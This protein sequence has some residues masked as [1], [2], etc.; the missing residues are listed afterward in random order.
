MVTVRY[1]KTGSNGQSR[2]K[3]FFDREEAI[4]HVQNLIEEKTGKGYVEL[5]QGSVIPVV[6][7]ED[8]GAKKSLAPQAEIAEVKSKKV[9]PAKSSNPAKDMQATPQSLLPL[10]DKDVA[11]NRL[12]AKHPRS[13]AELLEVLSHNSDKATRQSVAGNP[14]TLLQTYV[15]LGQQFPKQ[16]LANPALDLLLLTNPALMEEVPEALLIRLLKESEC[17]GT[18]LT[19]AAS[20][21]QAKVQLAVAMNAN[22]PEKALEKLRASK[23]LVVIDSVQTSFGSGLEQDPE[24]A[25]EQELKKRIASLTSAEFE[26][27]WSVEDLG[28]AQWSALPLALRLEKAT[29]TRGLD[30]SSIARVLRDT[31]RT[32][33]S[34]KEILP[35]FSWWS[36]ASD[37]QTP[38]A[39]LDQFANHPDVEF[40]QGVARNPSVSLVTLEFLARD[41]H[42]WVRSNIALHPLTPANVLKV[43]AR[44]VNEE[45]LSSVASNPHTPAETLANLAKN[46]YQSVR[47]NVAT[48]ISTPDLIRIDLQEKLAGNKE[49]RVRSKVASSPTTSASALAI[50]AKDR[51][52]L[53]RES[54]A[55]NPAISTDVA[56]LLCGD[57]D[58]GVRGA[59]AQNLATPTH[60]LRILSRDKES[61][62]REKVALNINTPGSILAELSVDSRF[63]V[64]ENVAGNSHAPPSLLDA[65][66]TNVDSS[67]RKCVASNPS[68]RHEVLQELADDKVGVVRSEALRNINTPLAALNA[69][70]FDKNVSVRQALASQADR[71]LEI[72][73]ALWQDSNEDVRQALINC[74]DLSPEILSEMARSTDLES[75]LVVLLRH[76]NLRAKDVELVIEKLLDI[77]ASKSA[78]YQKELSNANVAVRTAA[79]RNAVTSYHGKDPNKAA[80][81]KRPLAPVMA[82]C[83]GPFIEI[84]RLVKLVNSTDWLV[85]AS[86]ARH[87]GTPPNLLKKLT[88]DA[89]PLVGALAKKL[90]SSAA[91][92]KNEM[93]DMPSPGLDFG[94]AVA[95]VLNRLR[96][97]SPEKSP[98][99][100]DAVA[101]SVWG[102]YVEVA[103][104]LRVLS[105]KLKLHEVI[106]QLDT[107]L[108]ND[109][110][111]LMWELGCELQDSDVKATLASSPSCPPLVIKLLSA[112]PDPLVTL[113]VLSNSVTSLEIR[114]TL[115]KRLLTMR[116][117]QLESVAGDSRTPLAVLEVLAKSKQ[118][119]IRERVAGNVSTPVASLVMLAK[120]P[121]DSVRR[122]IAGNV[123]TPAQTLKSL[124]RQQKISVAGNRSTSAAVL[125]ALSIDSEYAVRA[126]V[127]KNSATPDAVLDRMSKDSEVSVRRGVAQNP[128]SSA[129]LLQALF[130][131]SS[132]DVRW[133]VILNR[134]A[135]STVWND[136]TEELVACG[137]IASSKA[138]EDLQA[139]VALLD[140]LSR[141][142]DVLLRAKV[143]QNVSV[144]GQTLANLT[145]DPNAWVRRLAKL[146]PAGP[147]FVDNCV[148]KLQKAL[149]RAANSRLG[150]TNFQQQPITRERF[151][152][153][154]DWLE[155]LPMDAD[156]QLLSKAARSKDWLVRF[157]AALHPGATKG[158]L[159]LL[160]ED[161]DADVAAVA[162]LHERDE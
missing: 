113:S 35:S 30:T 56:E 132:P 121:S 27:A 150:T 162:R 51:T 136:L 73:R 123:A 34:L 128:S 50:L 83:A 39:L 6:P 49:E 47:L 25:F 44:D 2:A 61:W 86:V 138:A 133:G 141:H 72:S 116:G 29:N 17:P 109:S 90:L 156:D 161:V 80:L 97:D 144:S 92:S 33:E 76:M 93:P 78:W 94:R 124:C 4:K 14:N 9:K 102:L 118:I 120:D 119:G 130:L 46:A 55:K 54:V 142:P 147:D 154:L 117:K 41:P 103:D 145:K 48:N 57:R 105:W 23:H 146:N 88:G 91:I 153:G 155:C 151:L 42:R 157:G 79:E 37:L 111:L 8:V 160:R 18:L 134:S 85:R 122:H 65:L 99:L 12:L 13:S 71:S 126:A 101:D 140:A 28:L 139:P 112:D 53:V 89:H 11:T 77:P 10:L 58:F 143:A 96:E 24:K 36:V 75:E 7:G 70:I 127:A 63:T 40:R 1:G 98:R 3:V 31:H 16:F 5:G 68:T 114:E 131:D 104:V 152:Y 129:T 110:S 87:V 19:W 43:M 82:L 100:V 67:V 20:H 59:L 21:S 106:L 115:R 148:F 95:E 66:S 64:R 158:I 52:V 159:K 84:D 125:E 62:V 22:A 15:R 60:L 81:A 108:D 26:E 32:F 137:W 135:P 45:V 149:W 107:T 74:S 69:K 38:A